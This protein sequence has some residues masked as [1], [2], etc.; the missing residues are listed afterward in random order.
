[1]L[2]RVTELPFDPEHPPAAPPEGVLQPMLWRL[3][4]RLHRDHQAA[5]AVDRPLPARCICCGANWPCP[6][7]RL[8]ERGLLAAF[9][10][11][12][13]PHPPDPRRAPDSEDRP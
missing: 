8:A 10:P 9:L 2:A 3:A 7:R 1:L 6:G 12:E 4:Y 13:P 11:P 5:H